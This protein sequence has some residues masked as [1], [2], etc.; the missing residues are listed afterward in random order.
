MHRARSAAPLLLVPTLLAGC[1][2]ERA[3][4]TSICREEGGSRAFCNCQYDVAR[5][6]LSDDE[7]AQLMEVL[8]LP[9]DQA[10]RNLIS[11]GLLNG[12]SFGMAMVALEEATAE[13]CSET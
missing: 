9:E 7:F 6:V 3:E 13:Q 1:F 12:L 2:G 10:Q 4:F 5:D 11:G 8:T